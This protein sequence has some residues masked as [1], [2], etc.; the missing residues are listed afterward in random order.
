M[1]AINQPHHCNGPETDPCKIGRFDFDHCRHL[2]INGQCIIGPVEE[3]TWWDRLRYDKI[4]GQRPLQSC[5]WS[6]QNVLSG[7]SRFTDGGK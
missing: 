7:K 4:L 6:K 2:T 1:R 5:P 3:L